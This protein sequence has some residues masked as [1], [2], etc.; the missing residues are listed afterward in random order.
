M[1]EFTKKISRAYNTG[2]VGNVVIRTLV[3]LGLYEPEILQARRKANELVRRIHSETV[4]YGPFSGVKLSSE[5]WW[6]QLIYSSRILGTYGSQ[7]ANKI[8]LLSRPQG[9]LINI[10]SADGFFAIGVLKAGWFD[11]AVCFEISEQ[12]QK[13]TAQNAKIN[14]LEDKITILGEVDADVLTAL[15]QIRDDILILCDIEGG[16][17]TLFDDALLS[18][19]RA[20]ALIIELHPHLVENGTEVRDE[21]VEKAG[22][23]FDVEVIKQAP[24]P[25]GAFDE[26]AILTDNERMLAF[27]EGRGGA[28]GWPV[29]T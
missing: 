21:F 3:R 26:L 13:F 28:G 23:Y 10:G 25:V 29:L 17:F 1:I 2:G 20:N 15:S 19:L 24:L 12:G 7:A 5:S 14:G 8:S 18:A 11:E 22:K 27:S 16:E 9:Q 4:A 6:G